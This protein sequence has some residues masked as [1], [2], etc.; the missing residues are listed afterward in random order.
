[1]IIYGLVKRSGQGMCSIQEINTA[2]DSAD[3]REETLHILEETLE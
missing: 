3:R 2:F 1:M